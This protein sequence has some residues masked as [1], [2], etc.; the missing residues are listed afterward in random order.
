M[1][2][3][4]PKAKLDSVLLWTGQAF[5]NSMCT[6][7]NKDFLFGERSYFHHKNIR[8]ESTY[9][10]MCCCPGVVE[11]FW[12]IPHI[13]KHCFNELKSI[14][15]ESWWMVLSGFK[16]ISS[17]SRFTHWF[18]FICCFGVDRSFCFI[19]RSENTLDNTWRMPGKWI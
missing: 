17:G 18:S 7:A 8:V 13:C 4:V 5:W 14:L 6:C 12:H 3:G 15:L 10:Y 19:E 2:Q 9:L 16:E 1:G 11:Y